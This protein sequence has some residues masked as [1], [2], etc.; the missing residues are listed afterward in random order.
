MTIAAVPPLRFWA[1][2]APVEPPSGAVVAAILA[3]GDLCET[4]DEGLVLLGLSPARLLR[5]DMRLLLDRDER[6][7]ALEVSILW[8]PA[9]GQM[10]RV[11]DSAQP[12]AADRRLS[13]FPRLAA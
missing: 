5:E 1:A 9:P 13:G 4:V 3:F 8:R 10:V 12:P 6:E 11:I 2:T 7:R